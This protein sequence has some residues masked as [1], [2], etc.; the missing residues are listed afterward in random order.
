[1]DRWP[2][3]SEDHEDQAARPSAA[4]RDGR[5]PPGVG[6]DDWNGATLRRLR[7]AA[8]LTTTEV[9]AAV[10]VHARTVT[11]WEG[12][13]RS[14]ASPP[15]ASFLPRLR[16]LLGVP[17]VDAFFGPDALFAPAVGHAGHGRTA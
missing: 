10:G 12:R 3:R 6:P 5:H 11:L 9:G 8:G 15:R 16:D 17:T 14:P 7:E 13:P 4:L 2:G 1:M